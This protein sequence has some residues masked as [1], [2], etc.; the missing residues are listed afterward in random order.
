MVGKGQETTLKI[1]NV[2]I[3]HWKYGKS[4]R[5]IGNIVNKSFT[6]VRNIIKTLVNEGRI[7]NKTG[8]GRKKL[9]NSRGE[10]FVVRKVKEDPKISAPKINTLLRNFSDKTVSN[11][12]VRR[13][14]RENSYNGRVA[15]KKPYVNAIN[16]RKR[17]EFAKKYISESTEFW[18]N[19]IFC[20]ESKFNI[21]GSDS[22]QKVWRK[23]NEEMHPKNL[24]ST[25]KHGGGNVMVWGCISYYGIGKL[26]F[27]TETMNKMIYLNVLKSNLKESAEKMGILNTSQFYQDNDPKHKSKLVQKWLL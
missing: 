22:Y 7:E 27:I 3:F 4:Y 25:I 9:L 10:R 8:R 20:D 14:L 16:R 21:S 6:T 18:R 1:R 11:E 26:E 2:V 5:E 15:R 19:V 17:L 24:C 12:T 13:V 23:P